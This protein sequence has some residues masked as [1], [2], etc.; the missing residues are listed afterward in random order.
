MEPPYIRPDIYKKT[1]KMYEKTVDHSGEGFLPIR[2]E[3]IEL[4]EEKYKILDI[5]DFAWDLSDIEDI[6]LGYKDHHFTPDQRILVVHHDSD[7]YE[8]TNSNG[9]MLYNFLQIVNEYQIPTE[10]LILITNHYGIKKEVEELCSSIFNLSPL[11]TIETPLFADIVDDE[12]FSNTTVKL[13]KPETLFCCLNGLARTH[14]VLTLCYLKEKNLL[15]NG[16][17]SY[18]FKNENI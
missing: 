4:V 18:H 16:I 1:Y 10:F 3:V 11:L 8:N 6:I 17:I 7:Y 14:R 15:S 13:Q 5:V 12:Q 9:Y 2:R